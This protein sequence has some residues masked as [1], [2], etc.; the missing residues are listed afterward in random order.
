MIENPQAS[1]LFSFQLHWSMLFLLLLNQAKIVQSLKIPLVISAWAVVTRVTVN[2]KL[3]KRKTENEVRFKLVSNTQGVMRYEKV[4]NWC[5][6]CT[7]LLVLQSILPVVG[8]ISESFGSFKAL[9]A[10]ET[11]W[12]SYLYSQLAKQLRAE[13]NRP[14]RALGLNAK[15]QFLRAKRGLGISTFKRSYPFLR[16]KKRW[17]K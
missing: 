9:K 13:R 16:V 15:P 7:V 4:R 17:S 14:C 5:F 12:S 6:S 1:D 8:C 3:V 10:R 2:E 11:W